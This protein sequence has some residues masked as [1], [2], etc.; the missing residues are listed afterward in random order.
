MPLTRAQKESALVHVLDKVLQLVPTSPT[1][2]ALQRAYVTN[3]HELLDIPTKDLPYLDYIDSDGTRQVLPR[4]CSGCLGTFRAYIAYRNQTDPIGDG[5]ELLT[6]DDFDKFRISDDFLLYGTTQSSS[7]TA[8]TVSAPRK[9]DLVK[10]FM[11][12]TRRDM[13]LF[14]TLTDDKLW[15]KYYR[16]LHAQACAQDLEEVLDPKYIPKDQESQRLFSKK[17]NFMFAVF[18]KTLQTDQGK[19]Y[20]QQFNDTLMLSQFF[21]PL[22][23]TC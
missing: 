12:G 10:E 23:N 16:S 13:N 18:E 9:P 15:D 22:V 19:A 21:V 5:W 17:Q 11:K 3:I 20:V 4:A 7:S 6:S 1:R 2:A 14:P 8:T